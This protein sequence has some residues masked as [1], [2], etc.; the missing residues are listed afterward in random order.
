M[1]NSIAVLMA[2]VNW[3]AFIAWNR[4]KGE[5]CERGCPV[6]AGV[7]VISTSSR[8]LKVDQYIAVSGRATSARRQKRIVEFAGCYNNQFSS[9]RDSQLC[10]VGPN[11]LSL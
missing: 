5:A 2:S 9:H 11:S 3:K 1:S 6:V 10:T 7:D 8:P 4:R